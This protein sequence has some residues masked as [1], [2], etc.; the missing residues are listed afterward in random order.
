MRTP[1][2]QKAKE[3]YFK[4]IYD[5]A[6]EI[7]CGCGCGKTIKAKDK[8]GRDK[9]FFNGHNGRK[10][11]NPGQHK[12]EW[13]YRNQE[14]RYNA[15]RTRGRKLKAKLIGLLG[16]KCTG[17]GIVYDSTNGAIFQ[18]HHEEPKRKS[19]PI[20][21]GSLTTK[22]WAALVEES[23]KCLLLCANCHFLHHTEAF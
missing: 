12:R 16:G 3:K 6:P 9:R 5:E 4:R 20:T 18:F 23:K 10:Y 21:Q 15:K 11:D 2:E 8:Y 22:A 13:N 7:L 14:A 19:F 17:C 1:I